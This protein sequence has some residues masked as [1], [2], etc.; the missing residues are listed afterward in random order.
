MTYR[1]GIRGLQLGNQHQGLRCES[2]HLFSLKTAERVTLVPVDSN[3]VCYRCEQVTENRLQ[4]KYSIKLLRI[5]IAK[6]VTHRST[7]S[8]ETFIE[9]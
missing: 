4:S 7:L 9:L 8:F 5:E 1:N 6:R 3:Q 2:E